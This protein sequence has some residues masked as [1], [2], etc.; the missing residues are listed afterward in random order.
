MKKMGLWLLA[1]LLLVCCWGCA[2][3]SHEN[4]PYEPDTPPP[5]AHEG[6]FVSDHGS[7]RF[8]G[9]GVSLEYDFDRELAAW[10]G[11]PE[12]KQQGTYVFLSGDLPPHGSVPVRYDVAHGL[13]IIL[14]GQSAVLRLGIAAEDGSSSHVGVGTVTPERI[15][16][17][18]SRDKLFTLTFQKQ[19]EAE[20]GGSQ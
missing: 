17:L 8:N 15:P 10:A 19:A 3:L 4:R 20:G 16:L 5:A 7:L 14:D 13:K 1:G 11:L 9:D 12:G 18:F 6:L 2:G